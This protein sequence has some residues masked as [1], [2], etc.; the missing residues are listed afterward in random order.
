MVN[1]TSL[2][3]IIAVIISYVWSSIYVDPL[4]RPYQDIKA[5]PRLTTGLIMIISP[6]AMLYVANFLRS[7]RVMKR[8]IW[9]LM[10]YGAIVVGPVILG[11]SLPKFINYGGQLSTWVPLLAFG[12]LVFNNQLKLWQRIFLAF[13][14]LSWLYMLVGL[15]FDW[16]SG[17][18]PLMTGIVIQLIMRS[19]RFI[20]LIVLGLAF[21][22]ATNM[23]FLESAFEEERTVSGDTR[24]GAAN[25][26][27]AIAGKH[28]LFGTGPT[29]YY[30][31]LTI[32]EDWTFQ[33]SHNNYVDILAQTGVVG[34]IAWLLM[35]G[36]IGWTVWRMFRKSR[37]V[38]VS[39]FERG[40]ASSL[41]TCFMISMIV[42]ALGDW[43][44]PFTYTQTVA[45]LSYTIQHWLWAGMAIALY[46]I[47][48]HRSL[49][50]EA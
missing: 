31:Y 49:Q 17:W 44:T 24:V 8:M 38:Q 40:L 11:I 39:G 50:A 23:D 36:S 22:V 3:F 10:I 45:G 5:L 19:R 43:V 42:M 32:Y 16:L 21:F 34:F 6:L 37:V 47:F 30:F 35:W 15:G 9:Y 2:V 12:Q 25:G 13:A 29:G 14:V 28:F 4:V 41:T 33:L 27:L 1:R 18:V 48:K 26:A 20:I 46:Q 7:T